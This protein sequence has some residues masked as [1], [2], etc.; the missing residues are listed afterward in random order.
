[1]IRTIDRSD[2]KVIQKVVNHYGKF[3]CYQYGV[4][5]KGMTQSSTLAECRKAIGKFPVAIKA[6]PRPALGLP[7]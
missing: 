1:M 4:P 7:Q 2:D 3:I 6:G 5:G